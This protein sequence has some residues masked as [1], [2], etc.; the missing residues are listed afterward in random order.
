[1]PIR[2]D[3]SDYV[4]TIIGAGYY[5]ETDTEYVLIEDTVGYRDLIKFDDIKNR[6]MFSFTKTEN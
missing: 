4:V 6:A 3:L 5:L 2:V 1:M